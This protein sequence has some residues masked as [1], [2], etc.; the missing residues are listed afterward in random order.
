MKLSISQL[1][2]HKFTS[3]CQIDGSIYIYQRNYSF[4]RSNFAS[5]VFRYTFCR[6]L[7]KLRGAM[8]RKKNHALIGLPATNMDSASTVLDIA[9]SLTYSRYQA[10]SSLVAHLIQSTKRFSH[11]PTK[12]VTSHFKSNILLTLCACALF[13]VTSGHY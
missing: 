9:L 12:L 6:P 7:N 3:F 1:T 10:D 4:S 13:I 5:N 11:L 2:V 8:L